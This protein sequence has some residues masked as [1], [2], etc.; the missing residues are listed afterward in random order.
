MNPLLFADSI[1]DSQT[2]VVGEF[3]FAFPGTFAERR[4]PRALRIPDSIVD[5]GQTALRVSSVVIYEVSKN[6]LGLKGFQ[7]KTS[8]CIGSRYVSSK[9]A[10]DS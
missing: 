2:S 8:L 10:R 7:I 4:D 1:V 3:G 5:S 9:S 6:G